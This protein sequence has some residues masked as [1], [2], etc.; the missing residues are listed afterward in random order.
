MTGSLGELSAAGETALRLGLRDAIVARS[1]GVLVASDIIGTTLKSGSIVATVTFN[2]AVSLSVLYTTAQAISAEPVVLNAGS[3]R[4][5]TLGS[6]S[7]SSLSTVGASVN[8]VDEAHERDRV[9]AVTVAVLLSSLVWGILWVSVCKCSNSVDRGSLP[10]K[11]D[12]RNVITAI[13][14]GAAMAR[15]TRKPSFAPRVAPMQAGMTSILVSAAANS[16]WDR[17]DTRHPAPSGFPELPGTMPESQCPNNDGVEYEDSGVHVSARSSSS[18]VPAADPFAGSGVVSPLVGSIPEPSSVCSVPPTATPIPPMKSPDQVTL[19]S[20]SIPPMQPL[21]RVTLTSP[22]ILRSK[23]RASDGGNVRYPECDAIRRESLG[24]PPRETTG[25]RFPECDAIRRESMQIEALDIRYI[26]SDHAGQR[27][28]L[29]LDAPGSDDSLS[30]AVHDSSTDT[31]ASG[32]G[33]TE[34]DRNTIGGRFFKTD[35]DDDNT[36]A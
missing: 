22:P 13:D 36:Q 35:H 4:T 34:G 26:L 17:T 25:M 5:V 10:A 8:D 9:I 12:G 27:E 6:M 18:S 31:A 20:P 33:R 19:T 2:S 14:D 3:L 29:Q 21:D 16:V 23:S 11:A 30:T 1:G 15:A 7:M 28:S 24:R 32:S